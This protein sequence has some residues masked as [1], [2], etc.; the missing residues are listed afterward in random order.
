LSNDDIGVPWPL[1]G[2]GGSA[3]L[4]VEEEDGA[5][6]VASVDTLIFPN[7]SV[8]DNADGSV[9][10]DP[11]AASVPAALHVYLNQTFTF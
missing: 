5:P 9:T 2:A 3:S 8:T 1:P 11:G 7:G 10:I 6:S 4:T